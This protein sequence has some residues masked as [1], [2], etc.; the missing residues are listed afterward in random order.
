MSTPSKTRK[1]RNAAQHAGVL[2][3][4]LSLT[5]SGVVLLDSGLRVLQANPAFCRQL[6]VR[7]DQLEGKIFHDVLPSP[8][9][10][11]SGIPEA[12]KQVKLTG[13]PAKITDIRCSLGPN[14]VMTLNVS[15]HPV[16][17]KGAGAFLTVWDD[18]SDRVEKIFEL[19]MLRQI[20][21]SMMEKNL[22]LDRLLHLVLTCVTA[23]SAL[24]FNRAFLLLVSKDGRRV[25]GKM[26]VGPQSKEDAYKVW[27]KLGAEGRTTLK[28]FLGGLSYE[29]PS[30]DSPL[31]QDVAKLDFS[32]AGTHNAVVSAILHKKACL[33]GDAA[34]DARVDGEFRAVYPVEEFVIVP[35][36]GRNRVLGAIIADNVYSRDAIRQE[37]VQL[38]TMFA[39]Q[40]G[41][42][43]E[44]A[45]M[46]RNLQKDRNQL[47]QAYQTL[48]NTQSKLMS[49]EKLAAIGKMAAHVS[50]E[51]RNPLV[52]IGGFARTI[53]KK[54]PQPEIREAAEIV[55]SEVTR[56]EKILNEVL[57]FS[58]PVTPIFKSQDLNEVI[59]E[60]CVLV[61]A[62]LKSGEVRLLCKLDD[63]LPKIVMDS[64]QLK[65]AVLN[66]L[67]N[68]INAMP[69]GGTLTVTTECLKEY[70]KI[71][72]TDTGSGI[73]EAVLRQLFT[74]FFTTRQT[75]TGLGLAVT[76][77]I[78][79]E[80]EGTIDIKSEEGKGTTCL[81]FLPLQRGLKGMMEEVA[82]AGTPK[83]KEEGSW[84]PY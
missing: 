1:P 71:D 74:P 19:S 25:C 55:V 60:S 46:Y 72:V 50:H 70:A 24:G 57:D 49:A 23:G 36:I 58:R 9:L 67:K 34:T 56:L 41:L 33:V 79:E 80:H 4:L 78:V 18:V 53:L 82:L 7:A 12:L 64:Q 77:Q 52:T 39:N 10:L 21:E 47:K 59:R 69:S 83:A 31:A 75:G 3:T 45:E 76:R 14:C 42:A 11:D 62:E 32:M 30:K 73:P 22:R 16:P 27:A 51:I 44:T 65:Q 26:G 63:K 66:I 28:D 43:L 20:N 68:A 15:I 54:N 61:S 40:A 5:H 2:E 35:L 37:Q 6:H 38:L 13:R 84:R 48:M 8:L 29:P 17:G 81:I